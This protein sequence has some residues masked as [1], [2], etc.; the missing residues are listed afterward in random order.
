MKKVYAA[1]LLIAISSVAIADW[2]KVDYKNRQTTYVD[3]VSTIKSGNTVKMWVLTDYEYVVTFEG[4]NPYSSMKEFI[5][6]DCWQR[7][8]REIY[9]VTFSGSMGRGQSTNSLTVPNGADPW[10]PIDP[11]S[12][13]SVMLKVACK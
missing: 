9:Y 2:V 12:V 10:K 6:Y 3:P 5:E 1:L 11:Q 4:L 8:E 13:S 7:Q